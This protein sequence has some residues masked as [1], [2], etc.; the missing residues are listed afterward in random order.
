MSE[1]T[2]EDRRSTKI[3]HVCP[4]CVVCGVQSA[5]ELPGTQVD[6]WKG[7]QF[8]QDAM[9]QLTADEREVIVSGT[10]PDCWDELWKDTEQ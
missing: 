10:H 9:P 3:L 2:Q 6:R 5:F 1:M 8:I 4:K 7:G